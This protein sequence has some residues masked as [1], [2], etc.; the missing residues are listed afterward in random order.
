MNS[1]KVALETIEDTLREEIEDDAQIQNIVQKLREIAEEEKAIREANKVDKPETEMVVL[2]VDNGGNFNP[3]LTALFLTQITKPVEHIQV[4][5]LIQQTV[6][7][8]NDRDN[9][10]NVDTYGEAAEVISSKMFGKRGMKFLAKGAPILSVVVPTNAIPNL[11]FD[12]ATI[13][14]SG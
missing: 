14:V 3:D 12:L 10:P 11:S 1:V 6:R 4:P 2:V 9:G 7:E 5:S 8:F 13:S